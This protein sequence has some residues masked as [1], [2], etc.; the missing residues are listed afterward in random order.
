[1]LFYVCQY[2]L[3]N[4][5]FIYFLL[6]YFSFLSFSSYHYKLLFCDLKLFI[7]IGR[8]FYHP[9]NKNTYMT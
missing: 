8:Y 7:I 2:I 6:S 3:Y 9:T 4:I 1:M 5:L